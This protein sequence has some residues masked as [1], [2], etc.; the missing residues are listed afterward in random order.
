[1]CAKCTPLTD[2]IAH[3]NKLAKHVTD[4]RT[5]DVIADMVKQMTDEKAGLHPALRCE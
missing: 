5:L 2:K 3:Y 1:M 4:E